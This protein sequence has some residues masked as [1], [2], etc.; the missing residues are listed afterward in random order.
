[1]SNLEDVLHA[2]EALL[3]SVSVLQMKRWTDIQHQSIQTGI[4]KCLQEK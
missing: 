1:M 3:G 4:F 2:M